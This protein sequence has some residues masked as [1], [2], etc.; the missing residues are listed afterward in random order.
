MT[1]MFCPWVSVSHVDTRS[2]NEMALGPTVVFANRALAPFPGWAAP[3]GEKWTPWS[4]GIGSTE[5][6]PR[7]FSSQRPR[8]DKFLWREAFV[9]TLQALWR[10]K[11]FSFIVAAASLHPPFSPLLFSGS[12]YDT[13]RMVGWLVSWKKIGHTVP[14]LFRCKNRGKRQR[15]SDVPA[16]IRTE[17]RPNISLKR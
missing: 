4:V 11:K 15:T 8:K 17:H 5:T 2:S 12:I 6:E 10:H 7:S 1:G 9:C 13:V 14:A 16:E 3:E